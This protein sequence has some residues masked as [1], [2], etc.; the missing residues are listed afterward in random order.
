MSK[1]IWLTGISGAGKTTIAKELMKLFEVAH[2]LD[3]D[4]VRN[5]PLGFNVG[6]DETSRMNHI[7]RMG[8]VAKILVDHDVVAICAFVS[9]DRKP[10]DVVRSMFKKGDFI[11]VHV[12][13][14]RSDAIKR[15]TKG[16]YKQCIKG[17]I[18]DLAGF[19]YDFENPL[20]NEITVDT[21]KMTV[22]QCVDKIVAYLK[23]LR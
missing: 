13:V 11:E 9:P 21:S 14:R 23:T 16:L 8:Q 12:N 10:R 4:E 15:D 18:S 5:S 22:K 20:N 17:E 3:G 2:L 19:D 6:F 7:L 1:C